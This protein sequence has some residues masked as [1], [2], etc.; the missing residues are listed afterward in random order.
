MRCARQP[1]R[2]WA[3]AR[4]ARSPR[5]FVRAETASS[6]PTWRATYRRRPGKPSGRKRSAAISPV[7]GRSWSTST[8][9]TAH[10]HFRAVCRRCH[11][12]RCRWHRFH[13]LRPLSPLARTRQPQEPFRRAHPPHTASLRCRCGWARRTCARTSATFAAS[14][15][16]SPRVWSVGWRATFA[17]ACPVCSSTR[18][19]SSPPTHAPSTPSSSTA[20]RHS[21]WTRSSCSATRS[22]T[23]R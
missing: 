8:Q 7:G 3:R 18:P 16:G 1:W 21:R 19:A 23:S 9:A 2:A 22:S 14:S 5:A 15:T 17:R 20:S 11:S 13:R 6:I 12:R 4:R 10:R